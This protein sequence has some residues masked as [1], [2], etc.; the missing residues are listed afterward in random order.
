[1][2]GPSCGAALIHLSKVLRFGRLGGSLPREDRWP[3]GCARSARPGEPALAC[4][5]RGW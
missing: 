5:A 4:R 3:C 2:P 1:L